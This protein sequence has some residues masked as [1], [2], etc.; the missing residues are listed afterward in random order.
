MTRI[1]LVA[2]ASVT[3]L[4]LACGGG[5]DSNDNGAAPTGACGTAGAVPV[6]A[7]PWAVAA[8]SGTD[9]IYSANEFD[10]TVTVLHRCTHQE[11]AVLDSG[12]GPNSIS[13][14]RATGVAFVS[15]F[16]SNDVTIIKDDAVARRI[17]VGLNPW[18]V[19]ADQ[20]AG[21]AYVANSQDGSISVVDPDVDAPVQ[22]FGGFA[23][24]RGLALLGR[25]LYVAEAGAN[26]VRALDLETGQFAG[27]AAVGQRPQGIAVDPEAGELWVTNVDDAS[28]SVVDIETMTTLAMVPVGLSPLQVAVD[29]VRNRAY[30]ADSFG[31]SITV[32]DT[33]SRQVINTY[34]AVQRP[35]D[36]EVAEDGLYIYVAS[37]ATGEV[38][39]LSPAQLELR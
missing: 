1:S 36:V 25:T 17:P 39:I 4:A 22:T 38:L 2:A 33:A 28:A 35:W 18:A 14:D 29:P 24:P 9:R 13:V 23:E 20:G 15:S 10:N 6:G 30:T 5:G 16:N 8:D 32:I 12:T 21:V 37:S 19:L 27:E 11:L 34:S 26:R 7:K 3:L 31:D